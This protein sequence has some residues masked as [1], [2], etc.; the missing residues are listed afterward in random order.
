M[1]RIVPSPRDSQL[2]ISP[3]QEAPPA[4]A[5]SPPAVPALKLKK[6]HRRVATD[7]ADETPKGVVSAVN[8]RQFL[9]D[10][11]EHWALWR[12]LVIAAIAFIVFSVAYAGY[13]DKVRAM[14][15]TGAVCRVLQL[16]RYVIP[17]CGLSKTLRQRPAR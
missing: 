5:A 15:V 14:C 7:T 1:V 17:L 11:Q 12:I 2:P 16:G 3:P 6:P 10:A 13:G 4:A 9:Y 8:L